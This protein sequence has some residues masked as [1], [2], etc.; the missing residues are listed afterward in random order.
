MA[1]K[2]PTLNDVLSAFQDFAKSVDARLGALESG[3]AAP[4]DTK[5]AAPVVDVNAALTTA[6]AKYVQQAQEMANKPKFLCVT[7]ESIGWADSFSTKHA[8]KK[9]DVRAM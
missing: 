9:H 8:E 2:E 6:K 7:C 1:T 4:S 5:D 3:K